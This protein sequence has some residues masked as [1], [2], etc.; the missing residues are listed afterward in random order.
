[1]SLHPERQTEVD[2]LRELICDIPI[3]MLTTI[4][5]DGSLNA[6]PM[7]NITEHFQGELW[8]FTRD[9]DPKTEEI[10]NNPQVN[11]SY[12]DSAHA[13]FV[14][15]TGVASV[16]Q[17]PTRCELMWTPEC[18]PWFPNGP[19]DPHLCLIKVEVE[20]ATYWDQHQGLMV[21]I[22]K[23]VKALV[24]GQEERVTYRSSRIDWPGHHAPSPSSKE[25]KL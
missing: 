2:H 13:R 25:T 24:T 11:V 15:A 9:D 5:E 10:Q 14:S 1:M 23:H 8:F 22:W 16:L 6:R 20:S 17:D 3:A 18:E 21:S 4:A 12:S 19:H 7:I